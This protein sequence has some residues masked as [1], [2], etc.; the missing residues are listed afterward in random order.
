MTARGDTIAR[1][2]ESTKQLLGRYLVGFT[3]ETRVAQ[4]PGMPNHVAWN[5]GHLAITMHRAAE[6]FDGQGPPASDFGAGA[7]KFNPDSVS[8]G[9][10]PTADANGY[11]SLARSIAIFEA[12]CDRMAAVVRGAS[13]AKLDEKIKWGPMEISLEGVGLRMIFHNGMHTGQIA[14]TRRGLGLKSIF[15]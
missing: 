4:L 10:K 12:A 5:L 8:F 14:D 9:S 11:P 1:G 7:D 2:I 3:D 13:D 6:K 15:S